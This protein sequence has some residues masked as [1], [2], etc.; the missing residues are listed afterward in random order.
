MDDQRLACLKERWSST[1]DPN[2]R[3]DRGMMLE[4]E[5]PGSTISPLDDCGD[6]DAGLE[7]LVARVQMP[8]AAD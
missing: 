3:A 6:P 1:G 4:R 7:H 8:D 5:F 2:D